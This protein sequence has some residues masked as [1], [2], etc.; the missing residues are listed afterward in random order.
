MDFFGWMK[1]VKIEKQNIDFK[2]LY[3]FLLKN[4]QI[5][6]SRGG[7]CVCLN[8]VAGFLLFYTCSYWSYANRFDIQ[9][10]HL[11]CLRREVHY[12]RLQARWKVWMCVRVCVSMKHTDTRAQHTHAHSAGHPL[13]YLC[14]QIILF[15]CPIVVSLPDPDMQ[16]NKGSHNKLLTY[17]KQMA[18]H[19]LTLSLCINHRTSILLKHTVPR[20]GA[21]FCPCAWASCILCYNRL[22]RA[23]AKWG[24][25]IK[26][27]IYLGKWIILSIINEFPFWTHCHLL[28]RN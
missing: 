15:A 4:T 25:L 12:A 17:I 26:V 11:F 23:H 22:S 3:H 10:H 28:P 24:W 13:L 5:F 19:K 27:C 9:D 18:L 21:A 16:S 14:M 1:N 6:I 8:G 2:T 7:L 20:E